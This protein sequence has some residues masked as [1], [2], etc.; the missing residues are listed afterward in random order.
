MLLHMDFH[1]TFLIMVFRVFI[2]VISSC[3][4]TE[5]TGDMKLT[6]AVVRCS[7][8]FWFLVSNLRITADHLHTV[9]L[10]HSRFI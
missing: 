9:V 3:Q 10:Y 8:L 6:T 5:L 2:V 1:S 4:R 7:I